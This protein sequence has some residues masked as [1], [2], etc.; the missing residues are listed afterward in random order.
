MNKKRFSL[1]PLALLAVPALLTACMST[2]QDG[3]SASARP[4]AASGKEN[5]QA[6]F[7]D[8]LRIETA[9]SGESMELYVRDRSIPLTQV[10]TAS[11]SKYQ[12][13]A[14]P[15]SSFWEQ[16]KEA[17]FVL[18]GQE[19]PLCYVA[20]HV[21]LPITAQ[22]N[23]PGW[24]VRIND[25]SLTLTQMSGANESNLTYL[26]SEST[27][28]RE[29]YTAKGAKGE[30]KL[31]V[32]DQ[33]CSDTMTGMPYPYT[34]QLKYDGQELNGC[35]G[36]PHQLLRGAEWYVQEVNG[37]KIGA[38]LVRFTFLPEG[39]IAGFSGCNR[40]F[41]QYEL[42]GEGI[43]FSQVGATR[44]ACEVDRMNLENAVFSVF[45]DAT[46]ISMDAVGA[47]TIRGGDGH[48][49]AIAL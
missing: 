47:L 9:A 48:I 40:F 37:K 10:K 30:M 18:D 29:R 33:V 38:E 39:R 8:H 7:C 36:S 21:P 32:T 24:Q 22:G 14:K 41:G 11:G 15:Y 49:R 42:T 16:G 2:P 27:A 17:S 34:A 3:Q 13:S 28:L 6:W 1:K 4:A 46:E 45:G 5:T 44:M 20:G 31:A 19:M 23:E 25:S 26:V 12:S 43:K 35:A